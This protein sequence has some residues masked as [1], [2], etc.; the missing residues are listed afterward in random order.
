[1]AESN[2][3]LLDK[4]KDLEDSSQKKEEPPEIINFIVDKIENYPIN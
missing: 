1:M 4:I 2:E 3:A